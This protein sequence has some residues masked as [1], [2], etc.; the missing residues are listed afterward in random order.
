VA[1][2]QGA[3]PPARLASLDAF[4][5][6]IMVMLAASGFGILQLTQLPADAPVWSVLDYDLGQQVGVHFD[7]A[8]WAS[9]F[10]WEG[11]P[12]GVAFWDLIQ[13]AFMFM[14]GVAMPYSFVRRESLGHGVWRRTGHAVWRA[15]VL[16]LLG[17]FLSSAW[18]Q[19]TNWTFVNVLCQIGLGYVFVYALMGRRFWIQLSVFVLILVGYW[20]FFYSYT[21]PEGY[22]FAQ[23]G[24]TAEEQ[25]LL[26]GNF[27]PWSKN[28]N[29][30][31][32]VDVWLLNQFP[33]EDG[34]PFE[35]NEGGYLTLNFVPS[36]A[37]MLLGVFCGQLLQSEKRWWQKFLLLVVGGAVCL[38]L[39][40]LAGQYACPIVKRI[41]TPSWV[42]FSG[43]WV[44]WILAAFYLVIDLCRLRWL[45]FPLVVVGMNSIVM[46]VMGQ[47]M[48]PWATK[49]F[50]I[51]FQDAL[52]NLLGTQVLADDMFGYVIAPT[53]AF[54]VFWLIVF[55]MYRQKY[56]V[57][58]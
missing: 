3:A 43:G 50:D 54:L 26:E 6:F 24:A 20:G 33:R 21:P 44:I 28:A 40:I 38:G 4:R 7:H 8:V 49:Q 48:R 56:F 32:R 14:V 22:D 15:I 9:D 41:W 17:V 55:W 29:A 52:Q 1:T 51:H 5:G 31:H 35:F 46:Y 23:V 10:V 53:S 36:I 30:A 42:L 11:I 58:I 19:Q 16:I 13:P 57:R 34:K 12:T 37:T 45:A 39:G 18:S 25:T 47:L 2:G 27:A